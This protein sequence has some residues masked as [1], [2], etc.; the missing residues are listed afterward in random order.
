MVGSQ[1]SIDALE[2]LLT[3]KELEVGLAAVYALGQIGGERVTALLSRLAE[4]PDF[5][6]FYDAIDEA[7]EEMDMMGSE[8]DLLAFDDDEDDEAFP[9][10]LR[11]N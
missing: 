5:E 8:F 6:E 9:D 1:S 2:E 4:D 10:D 3:D 11:L 7:L